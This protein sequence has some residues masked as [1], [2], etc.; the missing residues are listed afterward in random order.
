VRPDGV[1]IDVLMGGVAD[2]AGFVPGMKLLSVNG[3]PFSIDQLQ[4]AI[5]NAKGASA[6]I[7]CAV[8]NYGVTTTIALAYHGGEQ[9]PA[10]ARDAG[11]K[12]RLLDIAKPR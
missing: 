7:E 9:Y 4:R 8:E 2:K 6:P 10:L 5:R 1:I 11:T 3:K 12:D